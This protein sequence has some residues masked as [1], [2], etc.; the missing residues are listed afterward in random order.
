MCLHGWLLSTAGL[1]KDLRSSLCQV[2]PCLSPDTI[3]AAILLKNVQKFVLFF[4]RQA[5]RLIRVPIYPGVNCSVDVLF[6]SF[7]N[8]L[9]HPLSR[10]TRLS[11]APR[12]LLSWDNI[13]SPLR[14]S[15]SARAV[16]ICS[17]LAWENGH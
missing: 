5:I 9:C 6:C 13:K 10:R 16:R 15:F 8:Y 11:S 17:F 12:H 14:G 1:L 3:T 2:L 7:I 4:K